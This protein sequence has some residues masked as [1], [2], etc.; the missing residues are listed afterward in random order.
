MLIVKQLHMTVNINNI[1]RIVSSLSSGLGLG[2]PAPLPA[3]AV[4]DPGLH[5]QH[6]L[7]QVRRPHVQQEA[8]ELQQ[9]DEGPGQRG[10]HVGVEPGAHPAERR[11]HGLGGEESMREESKVEGSVGRTA[12]R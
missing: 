12:K 7:E 10:L 6:L 4:D 2:L 3:V 1:V 9:P 8:E 11:R 5:L